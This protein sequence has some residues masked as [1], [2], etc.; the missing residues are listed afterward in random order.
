MRRPLPVAKALDDVLLAYEM[1]GR[2]LPPD[3]G[4]PVRLVVPRWVGIASIKWVGDIEVSAAAAVLALEH[5]LYRM[6]GPA[7]PP[8][9]SAPLT[10]QGVKSA[11]ELPWDAE[12][13]VGRPYVL[14]GRS[15][16]G[17]GRIAGWR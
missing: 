10:L 16:S 11:F 14:H 3:H 6:F 4:Y 9:G 15:W 13:R 8:E 7:Y 17:D 1:N 12:L 5:R 2:P